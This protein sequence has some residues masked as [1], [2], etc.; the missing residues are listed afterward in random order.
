[1]IDL[2]MNPTAQITDYKM[3][4][5]IVLVVVKCCYCMGKHKHGLPGKSIYGTVRSADCGRGEYKIVY[6]K[7]E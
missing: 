1:M 5:G 4:T 7:I 2:E 3:E 6:T